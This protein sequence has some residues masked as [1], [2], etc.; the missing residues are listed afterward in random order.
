M[1][2]EV[3]LLERIENLGQMGDVVKVRPGFARNFLLPQQKALR[4]NKANRE[5]FEQQRT[6]LE[7]ENLT[8]R[9]EA[10]KVAGKVDDLQVSVIRQAGDNG[11]LYG[12]VTARDIAD[13]VTVEGATIERN[14]V[15]LDRPIKLLGL[16]PVRVRLH[17]EVSVTVTVNVAR[18]QA[19]AELQAKAGRFVSVDEQQAAE[20][21]AEAEVEAAAEE[22]ADAA[23]EQTEF[24][25]AAE[26]GEEEQ[27]A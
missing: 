10:E 6:Q 24:A 11:Q 2:V 13:A 23:A 5:L 1:A 18:S 20:E 7:A 16:H 27:P 21:A 22:A 4:A 14:Q 3:I 17:P 19:E 15:V 12:S 8:R 26:A 9:A 25:G